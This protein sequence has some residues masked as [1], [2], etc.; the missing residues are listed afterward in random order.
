MRSLM[1]ACM[2]R[3]AGAVPGTAGAAP[4]P[5]KRAVYVQN[6]LYLICAVAAV[7]LFVLHHLEGGHLSEHARSRQLQADKRARLA[8]QIRVNA[9]QVQLKSID[10]LDASV[11]QM[12]ARTKAAGEAVRPKTLAQASQLRN[13]SHEAY[14]QLQQDLR[15]LQEL[16]DK[17]LRAA[18]HEQIERGVAAAIAQDREAPQGRAIPALGAAN[19]W[20]STLHRLTDAGRVGGTGGD[21]NTEHARAEECMPCTCPCTLQRQFRR[22]GLGDDAD[23]DADQTRKH[24]EESGGGG[25]TDD[26]GCWGVWCWGCAC[27]QCGWLN[28]WCSC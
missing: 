11:A 13:S 7:Q 1:L 5:P 12:D 14:A 24:A 22:E 26:G 10:E 19:D 20:L 25:E 21:E 16:E 23:H 27:A 28:Y 2:H 6:A 17:M 9:A 8:L 4:S 18:D 15:M 3:M